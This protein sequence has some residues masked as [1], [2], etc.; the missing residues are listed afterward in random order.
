MIDNGWV[1]DREFGHIAHG[2]AVTSHAAQGKTVHKIF[3]GVSSESFPATNE[4]TFYVM[5]TRGKEQAV[6]FT[7]HKEDLMRAV[8]RPDEPLSA[9]ELSESEHNRLLEMEHERGF[10][11]D[12]SHDRGIGA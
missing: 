6:I 12:P 5:L 4:R 11:R 1:I 3:I 10:D 7:D 2:Y 8:T 9:T